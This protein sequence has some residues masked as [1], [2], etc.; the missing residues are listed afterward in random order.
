MVA[1]DEIFENFTLTKKYPLYMY[2]GTQYKNTSL[3]VSHARSG[4]RN[5]QG[6]SIKKRVP[7]ANLDAEQCD[8]PHFPKL[9]EW[10]WEENWSRLTHYGWRSL[11]LCWTGL[12]TTDF[13]LKQT[14]EWKEGG[15][16]GGKDR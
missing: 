1:N 5:K 6:F 7:L 11:R 3:P 12:N 13:F 2:A 10:A 16:K 4:V 8:Q 9:S 14:R 15:R